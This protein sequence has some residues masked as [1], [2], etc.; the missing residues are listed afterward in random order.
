MLMSQNQCQGR[1]QTKK[2][3]INYFMIY[4]VFNCSFIK[5]KKKGK[6]KQKIKNKTT[7]K[8]KKKNAL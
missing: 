8:K 6:K 4:Q 3:K 7:A 1:C 5:K 2:G